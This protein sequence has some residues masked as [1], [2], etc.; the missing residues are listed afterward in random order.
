MDEDS[1]S[2]I[3]VEEDGLRHGF[4]MIPNVILKTPILTHGAKLCYA[5]L[6]SY[7]WQDDH[8]FPGQER[9][10]SDLAVE[11]KAVIRYLKEL[12]EKSF[13]RVT[14]RGMGRSNMY[15]LVRLRD[16]PNLVHQEVPL[17]RPQDVPLN[18]H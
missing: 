4:T 12:Q 17:V 18:G 8:C 15:T 7:A 5:M 11:R 13:V 3:V 16:V 6:L 9:L 10:S 14:R 2:Q 1:R